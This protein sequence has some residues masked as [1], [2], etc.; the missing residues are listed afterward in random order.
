MTIYLI[1]YVTDDDYG[2][3]DEHIEIDHGYFTDKAEAERYI[4]KIRKPWLKI[5][6]DKLAEYNAAKREYVI[7]RETAIRNGFPARMF[8]GFAGTPPH[9]AAYDHQYKVMEV[10]P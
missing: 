4:E 9:K 10:E 6:E 1:V 8:K 3:D 7:E 5:Y 2:Y